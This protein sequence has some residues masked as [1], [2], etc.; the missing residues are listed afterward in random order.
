MGKS[1]G[2]MARI[3]IVGAGAIG[4]TFASILQSTQDGHEKHDVLLICR[5]SEQANSLSKKF[6]AITDLS[7]AGDVDFFILSTKAYDA[8][9]ALDGIRRFY[10]KTP[11]VAI[12]NGL[13]HFDDP[14]VIRG[15]TTYAATRKSDTEAVITAEGNIFLHKVRNSNKIAEELVRGGLFVTLVDNI[16]GL[17]WEKFFVNVGINALGAVTGKRNGELIKDDKIRKV[18]KKLVEEAVLVSEINVDPNLVFDKVVEVAILTSKNKSSMLQDI[19]AKRKTEIDFLN[20][21]VWKL[22]ELMG[23]KTPENEKI[24]REVKKIEETYLN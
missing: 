3:G 11:V 7:E 2:L 21:A 9:S 4:L 18:M 6:S 14:N 13:I 12:Q 23:I 16:G 1:G 10:P 24:T 22:G 20:G 15:V 5:R 19:G 8:F 17:L